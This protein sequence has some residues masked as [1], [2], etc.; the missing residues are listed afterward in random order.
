MALLQKTLI[1]V[2][3]MTC[4]LCETRWQRGIGCLIFTG[5]FPQKSPIISTLIYVCDMTCVIRDTGWQKGIGCLIF[6]GLFPQKSP[7]M[8]GSLA[9]NDLQL[10]ASDMSLPLCNTHLRV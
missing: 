6:I 1:Y 3:D 4:D 7:I 2:C 8:S 9:E 5:L 10:K